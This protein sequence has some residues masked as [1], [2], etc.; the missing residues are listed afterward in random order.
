MK[1]HLLIALIF[2]SFLFL[3]PHI[4]FS[5]PMRIAIPSF[6]NS[7]GDIRLDFLRE[8]LADRLS[9]KLLSIEEIELI[10]RKRL[11]EV[12]KEMVLHQTGAVKESM[13]SRMGKLLGTEKFL[14]GNILQVELGQKPTY[15]LSIRMVNVESGQVVKSWSNSGKLSDFTAMVSLLAGEILN[16]VKWEVALRNLAELTQ[17]EPPFKLELWTDKKR[18]KV[19]ETVTIYF[20]SEKDCYLT[21]IDITT[22]GKFYI[23]F[24]NRYA[25]DNYIKADKTYTLPGPDHPFAITVG[26]PKGFE[27]LK[28]IATLDYVDLTKTKVEQGKQLFVNLSDPSK[29]TRDLNLVIT[30]TPKLTWSDAYHE[31]IIE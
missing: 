9:E 5:A 19:G 25:T 13:V 21:L 24:P 4:I 11:K 1:R 27:R 22:S 18:Y 20:R 10:E 26:E 7:T 14:Y 23:L 12:L 28:A 16:Y 17:T 8:D 3:M 31:V 29:A 15:K 30:N 6:K 2:F